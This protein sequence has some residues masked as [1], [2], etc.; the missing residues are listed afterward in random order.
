MK[1]VEVLFVRGYALR[2]GRRGMVFG[3]RPQAAASGHPAAQAPDTLTALRKK[4]PYG[5]IS[6]KEN[7]GKTPPFLR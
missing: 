5:G 2:A 3:F 1:D 6:K 7:G 4:A